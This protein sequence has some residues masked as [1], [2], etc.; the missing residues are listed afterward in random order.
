MEGQPSRVREGRGGATHQFSA[1]ALLLP[2]DNNTIALRE[3]KIVEIDILGLKAIFYEI[4]QTF[5][6]TRQL[7]SQNLV[8]TNCTLCLQNPK[9]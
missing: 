1:A 5:T 7:Q 9:M 8:N 4:A 2:L 6:F 3:E